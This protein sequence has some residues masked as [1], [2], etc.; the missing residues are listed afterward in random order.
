MDRKKRYDDV[1]D[2][3]D[4]IKSDA[5]K[6]EVIME[7]QCTLLKERGIPILIEIVNGFKYSGEIIS[8]SADFVEINDK[9]LGF[10]PFFFRQIRVISPLQRNG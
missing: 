9:K 5:M 6:G 4:N 7:Q 3:N 8:V 2:V 10:V 1:N